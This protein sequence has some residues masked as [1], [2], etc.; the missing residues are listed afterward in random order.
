LFFE[1]SAI[2]PENN[3]A[4]MMR[5]KAS[6]RGRLT[7]GEG[8]RRSF[9]HLSLLTRFSLVSLVVTIMIAIGLGLGLQ[10]LLEEDALWSQ[11]ESTADQVMTVLNHNLTAADLTSP[12][13]SPRFD[14]LDAMIGNMLPSEHVVR[15]K[16]WDTEG[17][18]VYSD[19]RDLIG[20]KFP[21]SDEL[22]AALNGSISADITALDKPENA[23]EAGYSRLFEIY[24][25]LQPSNATEVLGA[26]EGYYDL[27]AVAPKIARIHRF[28]WEAVGLGFLILYA[29]LFFIVRGASS[30][31]VRRN[32]EAGQ[33]LADRKV[34]AEE[35]EQLLTAERE[36]RRL[37]ESLARVG[38]ALSG[39]LD[40]HQLL[41]LICRESS[42][43]FGVDATF[44]WLIDGEDLVGFAAYGK[45]SED[46]IGLRYPLYDP[47]LLGARVV[48]ER[49]P[50]LINH[51]SQSNKV[52]KELVNRYE[53]RSILGVPLMRGEHVLGALMIMD[54]RD[55]DRFHPK[56]LESA[57][58]LG[59]QAAIAI[60]T[61]QLYQEARRH[62]HRQQA[63]REIDHAISSNLDLQLTLEVVM[64]QVRG[65]L[66]A[67]AGAILLLDP[68]TRTLEFVSAIGFRTDGIKRTRL[69]LGEGAA[70]LAA[71]QQ[72]IYS[73][74]EIE[75][76]DQLP[77]RAELVETEEFAG[78]CVVPIVAKDRVLGV[79]EIF[80]RHPL[81]LKT[82]WLN[83]LET[84]AG[85]TAV[86]I[87]N[88]YLFRN[89]ER[90][91]AEL[92]LAYDLTIEGWARALELRDKD[93]IG[94][95]RRVTDMTEHMALAAGLDQTALAHIHRG[96]LL[97]D[98]GKISVPDGIL[99]KPSRLTAG[100][101][102]I[103]RQ[104]PQRAYDM[105]SPIPY[106]RE[107]LDI[108]YCHHERWDG[109]GFPRGLKG[110]EIPLA[111]R[112]FAVAD[113]WDA[114]TSDRPYR[115]AWSRKKARQYIV[116]EAGKHFDP[117][118]VELFLKLM[119]EVWPTAVERSMQPS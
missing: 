16:I 58:V 25:P 68:E 116:Q 100:E 39:M 52:K 84:L 38:L 45:D 41:E 49:R 114:L 4:N 108:P 103:M 97:H 15:I 110:E 57:V 81:L 22:Q 102:L 32:R 91:N 19:R 107:S 7:G 94:H 74:P 9:S 77:E 98:I 89:L 70:G 26:Y 69:L 55:P 33:Q 10:S 60:D 113:V 61:A 95:T 14:E 17:R 27:A 109:T 30:E 54:S 72:R 50:I 62:L 40:L 99:N 53:I 18:V 76:S 56:E 82:E 2:I 80:Q 66:K 119:S 36:Q 117:Q 65:Q 6:R 118:V 37:A 101:R 21:L 12:M 35:R 46:F 48:R 31:L 5:E 96:G 43:V 8:S 115:R 73:L 59:S 88:A 44:L 106:L 42:Q 20:Q 1:E 13:G 92:A 79:M 34:A 67:D 29:A 93:T 47:E 63:L 78:Y 3:D 104:H 11:A 105:L 85:Q 87:E 112:L 64:Q 51:A 71:E 83:F 75:S 23:G 111:A 86:A 24:V 90:S 28:V